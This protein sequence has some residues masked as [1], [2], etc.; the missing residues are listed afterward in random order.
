MSG[1]EQFRL[2]PDSFDLDP[3]K[4]T[5]PAAP[6]PPAAVPPVYAPQVLVPTRMPESPVPVSRPN[7][8][9]R[10]KRVGLGVVAI[11]VAAEM[12]DDPVGRAFNDAR[13]DLAGVIAVPGAV[14]APAKPG[15]TSRSESVP[16]TSAPTATK[17]AVQKAGSPTELSSQQ[18]RQLDLFVPQGIPCRDPVASLQI[19]SKAD[20]NFLLKDAS[21]ST[22]VLKYVLDGGKPQVPRVEL[23]DA[24]DVQVC[25]DRARMQK[26]VTVDRQRGIIAV[27]PSMLIKP[28]FRKASAGVSSAAAMVPA[29]PYWARMRRDSASMPGYIPLSITKVN[30]SLTDFANAQSARRPLAF[31]T[32]QLLALQ[33]VD[34]NEECSGT[35]REAVAKKLSET[36]VA[37]ATGQGV[38]EFKVH[39]RDRGSLR[40][41]YITTHALRPVQYQPVKG[42]SYSMPRAITACSPLKRGDR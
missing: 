14:E 5:R 23:D 40:S 38:E 39:I 33:R 34:A 41:S 29:A 36:M 28:T 25:G 32:H 12:L 26:A 42:G 17:E 15:A 21:G 6:P 1:F 19:K 9:T 7:T 27:D 11:V 13:N 37:Q 20:V 3:D 22:T 24:L 4:V 8:L 10:I 18:Q 35:V 31:R 30:A 16:T 2:D